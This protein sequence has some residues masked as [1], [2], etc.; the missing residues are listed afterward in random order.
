[1]LKKLLSLA[2]TSTM[3][4]TTVTALFATPAGAA[5]IPPLFDTSRHVVKV[6]EDFEV[7][8]ANADYTKVYKNNDKVPFSTFENSAGGAITVKQETNGNKYVH[9]SGSTK[10]WKQRLIKTQVNTSNSVLVSFDYRNAT[11]NIRMDVSGTYKETSNN[12]AIVSLISSNGTVIQNQESES[13]TP[14]VGE[15]ITLTNGKWT[16]FKAYIMPSKRAVQFYINDE[17]WG[18]STFRKDLDYIT[19]FWI[20]TAK[21]ASAEIDNVSVIDMG[22]TSETYYHFK[23]V[24]KLTFDYGTAVPFTEEKTEGTGTITSDGTFKMVSKSSQ[25]NVTKHYVLNLNEN[26]ILTDYAKI[27]LDWYVK[28]DTTDS[29]APTMHM[30]IRGSKGTSTDDQIGTTVNFTESNVKAIS[31]A[32]ASTQ[33]VVKSGLEQGWH[34][35]EILLD[36]KQHNIYYVVD[37]VM[38]NAYPFRVDLDKIKSVFFRIYA[39]SEKDEAQIDNLAF[40]KEATVSFEPPV[41]YEVSIESLI[42]KGTDRQGDNF[43]FNEKAQPDFIQTITKAGNAEVTCRVQNNV[44]TAITPFVAA[45]V[46]DDEGTLISVDIISNVAVA[47]GKYKDYE[48]DVKVP[49]GVGNGKLKVFVWQDA[50]SQLPLL[51]RAAWVYDI[52]TND[53]VIPNII[54]DNMVLQRNS[55]VNIFGKAP[56]GSVVTATLTNRSNEVVAETSYT[57]PSGSNEFFAV[58][59]LTEQDASTESHKLSITCGE[60]TQEFDSVL[61]GDVFYGSGQ[62]NMTR[63]FYSV[64]GDIAKGLCDN[65][66][67]AEGSGE[68]YDTLANQYQEDF[69]TLADTLNNVRYYSVKVDNSVS[70]ASINPAT[71]KTAEVWTT[72]NRSTIGSMSEILVRLA[73]YIQSLSDEHKDVPIGVVM[74]AQ[75]GTKIDK[76]VSKD[77]LT[78]HEAF[79]GTQERTDYYENKRNDGP[80]VTPYRWAS[81]SD[82][83]Y[84]CVRPVMPYTFKAAV[85]YQGESDNSTKYDKYV[86][87]LIDE[88]REGFHNKDLPFLVVQLPGFQN[89]QNVSDGA[90]TGSGLPLKRLIQENIKNLTDNVYVVVTNDSGDDGNIHPANKDIVSDRL[91]RTVLNQLDGVEIPYVGPKFVSVSYTGAGA[92]T[93]NF[94]VAD[95]GTLKKY[96]TTQGSNFFQLTDGTTWYKVDTYEV[97]G[98]SITLRASTMTTT[99]TGVRYAY[100]PEIVKCIYA[101]FG[102]GVNLPLVPFDTTFI[103]NTWNN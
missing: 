24:K 5:S 86:A 7:H 1:M 43:E 83:Y 84:D 20:G 82:L 40:Y 36:L 99:P 67:P 16:N 30:Y 41:D 32:G 4:L 49:S 56:Q 9:F 11:G 65:Y 60:N 34:T 77:V 14:Q 29:Y 74:S 23:E 63:G 69:R 44:E 66:E 91:A 73:G 31:V 101:D 28:N 15:A 57:V 35:T 46:Y 64:K 12:N 94:G 2:L 61:L 59:D 33:S 52:D 103:G 87:A 18:E 45:A 13:S 50:A 89:G 6:D 22:T 85:W 55:E 38:S 78:D 8:A 79:D 70:R 19:S 75:G 47:A 88:H 92:A 54:S 72:V 51:D 95:G 53:F 80:N 48:L 10:D 3:V 100:G 58:L 81:P 76:W 39:T 25:N 90:F 68:T 96:G 42:V 62:S 97:S 71:V 93:V 21:N 102:N 26:E 17:Y 98:N 37:G 27:S